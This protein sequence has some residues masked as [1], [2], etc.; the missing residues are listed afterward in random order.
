MIVAPFSEIR[1]CIKGHTRA[2]SVPRCLYVSIGARKEVEIKNRMYI[3]R[4]LLI[5]VKMDGTEKNKN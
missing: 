3:H 2:G 4:Y 5:F 1:I